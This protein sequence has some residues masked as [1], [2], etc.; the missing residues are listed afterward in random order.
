MASTN[1]YKDFILEELSLL[2]N[3]T[4]KPM[5]GEY[6]LYYKGVLFGGIYDDRLLV[7]MVSSNRKYHMKEAIPYK[8]AKPMYLV[9]EVDNKEMLK[10]IVLDTWKDLDNKK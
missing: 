4:Y 8:N 10:N 6:L 7:K 2:D 1:D 5:M 9:D 3:I